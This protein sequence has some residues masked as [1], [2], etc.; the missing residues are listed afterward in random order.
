MLCKLHPKS[1]FLTGIRVKILGTVNFFHVWSRGCT[2]QTRQRV[3]A[4]EPQLVPRCF[5]AQ[6]LTR[7]RI[8]RPSATLHGAQQPSCHLLFPTDGII[9][10]GV[11][12]SDHSHAGT[13]FHASSHPA[14]GEQQVLG[15][16]C[17]W[18]PEPSV[19]M[20]GLCQPPPQAPAAAGT[21]G[22][23]NHLNSPRAMPR[24]V[25]ELRVGLLYISSVP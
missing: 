6:C 4:Q 17:L 13:P 1:D 18:P 8:K 21:G 11:P 20:L 22:D 23:V 14:L 12:G 25:L 19:P 3:P 10:L 15:S 5:Q 2:F 7:I 24:D 9:F 16:Q